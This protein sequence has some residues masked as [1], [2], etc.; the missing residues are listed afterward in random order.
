MNLC[1]FLMQEFLF[2]AIYKINID[3]NFAHQLDLRL[4]VTD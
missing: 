2:L 1:M 3:R 4:S